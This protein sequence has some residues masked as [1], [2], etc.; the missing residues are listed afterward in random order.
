MG[1]EWYFYM[2]GKSRGPYTTSQMSNIV[3]TGKLKSSSKV[4]EGSDSA[5]IS[6]ENS[7]F[8]T[9]P[10]V[11]QVREKPIEVELPE[12]TQL[13]EYDEEFVFSTCKWYYKEDG[14]SLGAFGSQEMIEFY[15][16][17]VINSRTLVW[18]EGLADWCDFCKTILAVDIGV[19]I[20]PPVVT[21]KEIEDIQLRYRVGV[22][23]SPILL[24]LV[25]T[26]STLLKLLVPITLV[27][28][29]C[30]IL[31]NLNKRKFNRIKE[32]TDILIPILCIETILLFV[33]A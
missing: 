4:R 18:H 31:L 10:I 5:W 6:L 13:F 28:T 11:P 3:G 23:I 22:G 16:D 24:L 26:P 8:N 20:L 1:D 19:E 17:D 12:P 25:G 14:E 2:N 30:T 21:S 9:V 27:L 15:Y 7:Q 32:F 33:V 29:S